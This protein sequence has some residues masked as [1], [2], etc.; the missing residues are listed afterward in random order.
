MG[1]SVENIVKLFNGERISVNNQEYVVTDFTSKEGKGVFNNVRYHTLEVCDFQTKDKV[2]E[3]EFSEVKGED[4][5]DSHE[6][7][8][9]VVEG[10]Y[11]RIVSK[12]RES[13]TPNRM[14]IKRRVREVIKRG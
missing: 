11:Q 13:M 12:I 6:G 2:C 1:Y 3:V 14:Y 4:G 10:V 7:I 9:R 8:D 5:V